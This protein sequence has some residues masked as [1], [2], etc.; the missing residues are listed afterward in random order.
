MRNNA[1]RWVAPIIAILAVALSA[2]GQG[3]A[4]KP[5]QGP[6]GTTTIRYMNFSA[7]GGN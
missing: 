4:T 5:N 1:R 7:N 3:S 2:C 6:S